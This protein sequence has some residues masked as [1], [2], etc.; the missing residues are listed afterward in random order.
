MNQPIKGT[1]VGYPLRSTNPAFWAR[2][3]KTDRMNLLFTMTNNPRRPNPKARRSKLFLFRTKTDRSK[4]RA[5]KSHSKPMLN[6]SNRSRDF[7]QRN[8]AFALCL[9]KALSL[10]MPNSRREFG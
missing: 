2:S 4:W 7:A 5:A 1:T 3:I 8:I 6:A 9:G 10:A